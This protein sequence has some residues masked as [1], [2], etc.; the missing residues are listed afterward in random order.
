MLAMAFGINVTMAAA[1][2]AYLAVVPTAL[3]LSRLGQRAV[4]PAT[5]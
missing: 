4:V 1:G 3:A 5:A 2:I